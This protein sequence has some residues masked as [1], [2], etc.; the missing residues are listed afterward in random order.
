MQ[1]EDDGAI[2]RELP[3]SDVV[4]DCTTIVYEVKVIT[5]DR[6]GAGTGLSSSLSL[7]SSIFCIFS[8]SLFL[9]WFLLLLSPFFFFV[10]HFLFFIFTLIFF[11]DATVSIVL[12]G[13]T[14]DS[15]KPKVLQNASNNFER[16]NIF[17]L[18]LPSLRHPPSFPSLLF[19]HALPLSV[20]LLNWNR[21]N[22]CFWSRMCRPRRT[23]ENPNRT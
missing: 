6:R 22:G 2:V 23:Q 5:G 15:G 8:F 20:L 9:T 1:G 10:L 12:F 19:F 7:P 11:S 3:V 14:E 18:C 13:E 17:S 16:G 4:V 21:G